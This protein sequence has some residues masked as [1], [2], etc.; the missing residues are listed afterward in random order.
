M[1]VPRGY[2]VPMDAAASPRGYHEAR[3][4]RRAV[5]AADLADLTGPASG[6]VVLPDRL[7][8]SPPGRPWNLDYPDVA[9]EMYAIVL[10]E[11]IRAEELAEYLN[12]GLLAAF[13]PRLFLPRGVRRAWEERHPSLRATAAA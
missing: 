11:A 4:G 9:R 3:P 8:W 13:W 1:S 6:K 12:A 10:N 7:F 5:V 2:P